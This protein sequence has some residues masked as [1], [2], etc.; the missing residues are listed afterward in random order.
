VVF[1]QPIDMGYRYI[2]KV[3][4]VAANGTFSRDSNE[5]EFVY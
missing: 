4:A 1:A 2:Y 3:A 5:I